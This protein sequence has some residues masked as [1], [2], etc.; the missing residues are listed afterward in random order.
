MTIERP[1]VDD[2]TTPDRFTP[3]WLAT[4]FRDLERDLDVYRGDHDLN[5]GMKIADRLTSAAVLVPLVER[6][7][8]I[9]TLF[10]Q[11]TSHLASH[12]G[13]I[14]FPGGRAEPEDTSP[15]DTALRE[16]EEEVGLTRDRIHIIGR[17]DEYIT[18][19]GYS[20]TPVVGLVQPPFDIK[21]DPFEVE[22]VF[23][24]PLA[25]LMDPANH[26]R[27]RR[28]IGGVR[29]DFY[30]MPYYDW[31]IWGATAGM[32]RNMYD[33]LAETGGDPDFQRVPI[34]PAGS[35]G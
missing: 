25:F 23:E 2:V 26:Q 32:I 33:I 30:A 6:D 15:E 27:H 18:R 21:P 28:D 4:R 1:P 14:S 35:G 16:T 10:T 17:L 31:F 5:P 13:Q 19:T 7:G 29:R 34:P 8:E 9:T 12:A 20:V 22:S 3:D 11:R 24:V